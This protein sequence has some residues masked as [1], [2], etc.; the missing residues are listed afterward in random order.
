MVK[1]SRAILLMLALPAMMGQSAIAPATPAAPPTTLPPAPKASANA[2]NGR[3]VFPDRPLYAGEVFDLDL[4]WNVDWNLFRNLD[5]DIAWTPDPLVTEGWQPPEQ[6]IGAPAD[7][8][9]RATITLKT[10]AMA[11]QPGKI[12]LKQASQRMQIVTGGYETDGVK[13][14][15]LGPVTAQSAKAMLAVQPL[16]APPSGFAGAVGQFTMVSALAKSKGAGKTPTVGDALTWTLSLSGTGNWSAFG[17]IPARQLPR[18]FDMVGTPTQEVGKDDALFD[19][20]VKESITIVPRQAGH[21]A[22]GPVEMVAFDP[23]AGRYV[24]ITAPA[25][26]IDIAPGAASAQPPAYEAEPEKPTPGGDLPARI[27]GAGHAWAP[28][29]ALWWRLGLALPLLA[30]LGLWLILAH[31]RA[32]TSDPDR[33]PRRAHKRLAAILASLAGNPPEPERKRLVRAWQREIGVR[34]KLAQAAPLAHDFPQPALAQLWNESETYLYGHAANLSPEWTARAQALLEA[35]GEPPKFRPFSMFE[36]RHLYPVAAL[37]C[38]ALFLAGP[39]PS[40]AAGRDPAHE[41]A[42]TDWVARYDLALDAASTGR[43]GPAAAQA[44]I[45]WTQHPQSGATRALWRRAAKEAGY[46][47]LPA[48]GIPIPESARGLYSGLVPPLAWQLI[49]LSCLFVAAA[50]AMLLL[51]A[52]FGRIRASRPAIALMATGAIGTLAGLAG[53]NGYG[54]AGYPDAAIIW[55]QVPLRALPVDTPDDESPVALAPGS[56]GRME[57]G[58]MGWVRFTLHDG[59]SGWVRRQEL[60]PLWRAQP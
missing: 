34:L 29:G 26:A 60:L 2:A 52:R 48:G 59:R 33:L 31:R 20:T 7:A 28:L 25:I 36:P 8:N 6:K 14:S 24:T 44:G 49:T 1:L 41:P 58:F 50:G 16:P 46:G 13:I 51:L 3:F 55:E 27:A 21:F 35:G 32:W 19:R 9:G 5:G 23:N 39:P 17:G 43:W 30:C 42:P 38:L 12:A 4:V 47:G 37:L 53:F 54:A 22:L 11:I 15:T 57:T 10:R 56:V 45:A 18:A 40:L